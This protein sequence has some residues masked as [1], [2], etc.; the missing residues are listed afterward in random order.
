MRCREDVW[1]CMCGS[2][3]VVLII[4]IWPRCSH[5]CNNII[6]IKIKTIIII[7]TGKASLSCNE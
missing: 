2:V 7:I 3:C 1:M 5:F 6:V 4:I